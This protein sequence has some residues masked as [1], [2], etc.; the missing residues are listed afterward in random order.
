MYLFLQNKMEKKIAEKL[1]QDKAKKPIVYP[2][3]EKKSP[4]ES[5]YSICTTSTVSFNINKVINSEPKKL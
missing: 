5:I 3:A 2:Y 4:A 1:S